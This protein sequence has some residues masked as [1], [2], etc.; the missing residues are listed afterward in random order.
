[1]FLFG[2]A[3]VSFVVSPFIERTVEKM[4]LAGKQGAGFMGE[5][6][7]AVLF[8]A[9]LFYLYFQV[10]TSDA[11]VENILPNA[12]HNKETLLQNIDLENIFSKS[13]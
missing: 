5:L 12:W 3:F 2:F 4:H 9:G 11:G 6:V 1:M 7:V 13:R 10:Y 8:F